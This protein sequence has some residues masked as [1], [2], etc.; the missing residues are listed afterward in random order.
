[1]KILFIYTLYEIVSVHKPLRSQ[2]Q[3]QFGISYISSLLKK[4]GHQTKL[5]VLSRASGRKTNETMIHNAV[6]SFLP[7]LICFTAV[8]SEYGFIAN[9]AKYLKHCYKDIYFLIGGVHVTLNPEKVLDDN[10]DAL[11]IG[12]GE[13]PTLELVNCLGKG[14]EPTNIR[15]LWI[16]HGREI[17]R[18]PQRSFLEDLDSV[19]FLDREMWQDWI[20]EYPYSQHSILLGRGCPFECTYCS[21]NALKRLSSGSYIRLRTHEKIIEELKAMEKKFPNNQ[22]IYLEIETFNINKFWSIELCYKLRDLNKSL[23]KP[24]KFGVNLRI[25]PNANFEDIFIACKK[26]NFRFINVGIESGSERIRRDVL[27]RNYNNS[28]IMNTVKS[29]KKHNLQIAFYNL[30]GIP[31]E[32]ISDVR[33]T[34]KINRICQPDWLMTTIFFP[35][36]GT[37]LYS[38]CES[39]NY[40]DN[41][42]DTK[43]ERSKAILNLPSFSKKQIRTVYEWFYYDVYKGYKP[44]H[45]LLIRVFVTKL[46]SRSKI[47]NIYLF[48]INCVFY[49]KIKVIYKKYVFERKELQI[50]KNDT[51]FNLVKK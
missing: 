10:F 24:L 5:V 51:T 25:T 12:E 44:L 46:R 1:M 40:L 22:N 19:P 9:M 27:K 41:S 29:A 11:C 50:S 3:I 43:M 35:Y 32:T 45:A 7:Q 2:E 16:K 31:G 17:E 48:F 38:L 4:N 13:Y 28:D 49:K 8:S 36:P 20:E 33:E 47:F 15:N 34:I 18:N 6:D 26:S 23:L 21:N 30:I 14:L 37:D 42:F 39:N